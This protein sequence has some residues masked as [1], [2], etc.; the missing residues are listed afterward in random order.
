MPWRCRRSWKRRL[1]VEPAGLGIVAHIRGEATCGAD[2]DQEA[3]FI[4]RGRAGQFFQ[5]CIVEFDPQA[6]PLGHGD[7]AVDYRHR[8]CDDILLP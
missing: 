5:L 1:S 2:A 4:D 6:R 3:A 8:L 7:A